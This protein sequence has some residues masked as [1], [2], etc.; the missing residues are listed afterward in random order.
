M[1]GHMVIRNGD[2]Y[3]YPWRE[4]FASIRPICNKFIFCE[5]FSDKDNT[6]EELQEMADA[7]P[8]IVLIRGPWGDNFRVLAE[9]TNQC[10][11]KARELGP[12]WHYQIQGDEIIHEDSLPHIVRL[13]HA[14]PKGAGVKVHYHHFM[15][16]YETE[17]DFVYESIV[18]MAHTSS[19]WHSTGDACQLAGGRFVHD[20]PEIQVYHYG[21][22]HEAVV[23]LRKE[24][25]FQAMFTE[26]GF[27]DPRLEEMAK[28]VGGVDYLYLFERSKKWKFQGAHPAVMQKRIEQARQEGWLQY[29]R[30]MPC[31]SE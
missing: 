7:D 14:L 30:R 27:P 19:A 21:K 1:I 11:N 12:D 16:N 9:R 6:W 8:A 4:A 20:A 5:C 3:D 18:R 25:D 17:F 2:Y 24:K 15:G 13:A 31:K 10:I 23:A 29:E 28:A 22:V 26:L